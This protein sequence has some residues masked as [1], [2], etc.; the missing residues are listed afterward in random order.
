MPYDYSRVKPG[1][2]VR[3]NQTLAEGHIIDSQMLGQWCALLTIV[4]TGSGLIEDKIVALR[5]APPEIKQA[6]ARGDV[7]SLLRLGKSRVPSSVALEVESTLETVVAAVTDMTP[8]A[9]SQVAVAG[10]KT[11]SP[12]VESIKNFLTNASKTFT[13]SS[14]IN[15]P[16]KR[17]LELVDLL[18]TKSPAGKSLL[19]DIAQELRDLYETQGSVTTLPSITAEGSVNVR[20]R[21]RQ[22]IERATGI[23]YREANDLTTLIWRMEPGLFLV[24]SRVAPTETVVV[25]AARRTFSRPAVSIPSAKQPR[26]PN[27]SVYFKGLDFEDDLGT[28]LLGR[29]QHLRYRALNDAPYKVPSKSFSTPGRVSSMPYGSLYPDIDTLIEGSLTRAESIKEI[30]SKIKLLTEARETVRKALSIKQ[31]DNKYITM[32]KDLLGLDSLGKDVKDG[33][34][35]FGN[36]TK[37][38]YSPHGRLIVGSS[39]SEEVLLTEELRRALYIFKKFGNKSEL[40]S[41]NNILTT[42]HYK[43]D[44][45]SHKYLSPE[46]QSRQILGGMAWDDTGPISKYYERKQLLEER[47][48]EAWRDAQRALGGDATDLSDNLWNFTDDIRNVGDSFR[49]FSETSL[50]K[51]EQKADRNLAQ[52]LFD[53]ALELGKLQ[54]YVKVTRNTNRL[55]NE[56][57]SVEALFSPLKGTRVIRSRKPIGAGP[58]LYS[59]G[60]RVKQVPNEATFET[61]TSRT[62]SRVIQPDR[63]RLPESVTAS[64]SRLKTQAQLRKQATSTPGLSRMEVA[65]NEP[66]GF[67]QNES[68]LR[69]RD[70]LVYKINETRD[71]QG[72]VRARLLSNDFIDLN[73]HVSGKYIVDV[74]NQLTKEMGFE[75]IDDLFVPDKTTG[76]FPGLDP[77]IVTERT[78]D[79]TRNDPFVRDLLTSKHGAI[80]WTDEQVEAF[81]NFTAQEAGSADEDFIQIMKTEYQNELGKL[82]GTPT[83]LTNAQIHDLARQNAYKSA[84][85]EMEKRAIDANGLAKPQGTKP[86]GMPGREGV[87]QAAT[88]YEGA[89]LSSADINERTVLDALDFIKEKV[90]GP[91]AG[92]E[93]SEQVL[94]AWYDNKQFNEEKRLFV[95]TSEILTNLTEQDINQTVILDAQRNVVTRSKIVGNSILKVKASN[96][97][98]MPFLSSREFAEA[99]QKDAYSISAVSKTGITTVTRPEEGWG[100]A[101]KKVAETYRV[102]MLNTDVDIRDASHEALTDL[103]DKYN[104][105]YSSMTLAEREEFTATAKV[106]NLL[107]TSDKSINRI[108]A[109]VQQEKLAQEAAAQVEAAVQI[110]DVDLGTGGQ[111]EESLMRIARALEDPLNVDKETLATFGFKVDAEGKTDIDIVLDVAGKKVRIGA[112]TI[113]TIESG[114]STEADYVKQ[115]FLQAINKDTGEKV[116]MMFNMEQLANQEFLMSELTLKRKVS[117][118]E[119]IIATGRESNMPVPVDIFWDTNRRRAFEATRVIETEDAAGQAI[120]NIIGRELEYDAYGNVVRGRLANMI[121]EPLDQVAG[122]ISN[123]Y[124]VVNNEADAL[125]N[126]MRGASRARAQG[127]VVGAMSDQGK[128]QALEQ[129]WGFLNTS[130][131]QLTPSELQ[132]W[133][134]MAR[135]NPVLAPIMKDW[136]AREAVMQTGQFVR[137]KQLIHNAAIYDQLG[138]SGLTP[139]EQAGALRQYWSEIDKT[140]PL[141]R[142]P[143]EGQIGGGADFLV[144]REGL[145]PETALSIGN[146]V[147]QDAQAAQ[148]AAWMA[149]NPVRP[150]DHLSAY[151]RNWEAIAES[152]EILADQFGANF[153][154]RTAKQAEYGMYTSIALGDTMNTEQA[155][156]DARTKLGLVIS[157][158]GIPDLRTERFLRVARNETPESFWDVFKTGTIGMR[159]AL[160]SQATDL[161]SETVRTAKTWK[162]LLNETNLVD[163]TTTIGEAS[164]KQI[165][166]LARIIQRDAGANLLSLYE[167]NAAGISVA[168]DAM[169][170]GY[171]DVTDQILTSVAKRKVTPPKYETTQALEGIIEKFKNPSENMRKLKVPIIALGAMAALALISNP[172]LESAES[173]EAEVV[174]NTRTRAASRNTTVPIYARVKARFSG[175]AVA[176]SYDDAELTSGIQ[177]AMDSLAETKSKEATVSTTD[178][179]AKINKRQVDDLAAQ[180]LNPGRQLHIR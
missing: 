29:A 152:R 173:E 156:N 151:E 138:M 107:D 3:D 56:N 17:V 57:T 87:A 19:E 36:V 43:F 137:E 84:T 170:E 32:T 144:A 66:M 120:T 49:S 67:K 105:S 177:A 143:I 168:E 90:G 83:G 141:A 162:D 160:E 71:A 5:A 132:D 30:D 40:D 133:Q 128:A 178:N 55:N 53:D 92:L 130:T 121:S 52:D 176:N 123:K 7:Q 112:P 22:L 96:P 91:D 24:S 88:D 21:I 146:R 34:T 47:Q 8:A 153:A 54:D 63:M 76:G 154:N 65:A 28:N 118:A 161:L 106:T 158:T 79:Y 136:K 164:E 26:F 82:L 165:N 38:I 89:A 125:L 10:A 175:K 75:K 129:R 58:R 150:R 2:K 50:F 68:R 13:R 25:Q 33:K 94:Q 140:A 124:A 23:S 45:V 180:T 159:T 95:K 148:R 62:M 109:R 157:D 59:K 74:P 15:T 6:I 172:N 116:T 166:K 31:E 139:D 42:R 111:L 174:A 39:T 4:F 81:Y 142:T 20:L 80:K 61:T 155:V 70:G 86:L 35:F 14:G 113:K 101:G 69:V 103:S 12:R 46:E 41:I 126:L 115:E 9:A 149:A 48:L 73:Q 97:D 102:A 135:A 171:K 98:Q 104:F 131:D 147:I 145:T 179:R 127:F 44:V 16:P 100:D 119:R 134:S 60:K 110:R 108:L 167:Q 93:Q 51:A 163:P 117:P 77:G 85:A 11:S 99:I 72:K 18:D 78:I 122:A 37:N 27:N 1:D 64:Y 114:V 169:V